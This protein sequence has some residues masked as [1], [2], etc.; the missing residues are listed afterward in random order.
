[1]ETNFSTNAAALGDPLRFEFADQLQE[2]P[3][4]AGKSVN[5]LQQSSSPENVGADD[6]VVSTSIY[7]TSE[8]QVDATVKLITEESTENGI[9]AIGLEG[10]LALS[11]KNFQVSNF[12]SVAVDNFDYGAQI[13]L[14]SEWLQ[15]YAGA[16]SSI[17]FSTGEIEPATVFAGLNASAKNGTAF[18]AEISRSSESTSFSTSLSEELEIGDASGTCKM[19]AEGT[20]ANDGS[21]APDLEVGV[22]CEIEF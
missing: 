5:G 10:E 12:A 19:A 2:T 9:S 17:A 16:S 4:F 15:A 20:V 13:Q 1:M 6:G 18:N 8:F 21:T 7:G 3:D 22:S 11:A 14:G